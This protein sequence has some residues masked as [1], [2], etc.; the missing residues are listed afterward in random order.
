MKIN[1]YDIIMQAMPYHIIKINRKQREQYRGYVIFKNILGT[2]QN[3]L[4][5]KVMT[6]ILVLLSFFLVHFAN[7]AYFIK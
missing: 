6:S 7:I 5:K 2:E 3:V 4:L 1:I